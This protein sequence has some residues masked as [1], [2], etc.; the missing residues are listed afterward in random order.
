MGIFQITH[1][2]LP[3]IGKPIGWL[4]PACVKSWPGSGLQLLSERRKS[5][6]TSQRG[7]PESGN[8]T[9]ARRVSNNHLKT[10]DQEFVANTHTHSSSSGIENNQRV[11]LSVDYIVVSR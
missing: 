1:N 6:E 10:R 4:A 5:D 7:K 11:I 3:T 2:L 8:S 9:N